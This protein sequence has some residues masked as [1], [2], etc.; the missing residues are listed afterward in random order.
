MNSKRGAGPEPGAPGAM[1][2]GWQSGDTLNTLRAQRLA[3]CFRVRPAMAD[4][5]AALIWRE[6]DR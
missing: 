2:G 3:A 4:T 6:A 1:L 5:V